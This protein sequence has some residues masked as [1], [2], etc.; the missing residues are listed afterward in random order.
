MKKVLLAVSISALMLSMAGAVSAA[1]VTPTSSETTSDFS[2]E[3][4][5]MNITFVPAGFHTMDQNVTLVGLG[6][7]YPMT[8]GTNWLIWSGSTV[9]K[10]SGNLIISIGYGH[11][12]VGAYKGDGTL[13]GWYYVD[14]VR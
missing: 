1:P 14:V 12:Q 8:S 9:V 5:R 7:K 2:S 3:N 6:Q 4:A 13:L 11:A 10:L